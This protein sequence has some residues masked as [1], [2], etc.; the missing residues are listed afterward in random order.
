MGLDTLVEWSPDP[1][2][3]PDRFTSAA[4]ACSGVGSQNSWLLGAGDEASQKW[5]R[6]LTHGV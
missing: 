1:D 5:L 2:G 3:C 6:T 4:R